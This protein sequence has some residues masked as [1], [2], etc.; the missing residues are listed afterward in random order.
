[1]A[2]YERFGYEQNP[3]ELDPFKSEYALINHIHVVEDLLYLIKSGSIV[4]LEGQA[5]S[6]KT[7][8][9][10]HIT[11][12]LGGKKKVAY[13]DGHRLKKDLDIEQ[14]LN[15][16]DRSFVTRIFSDKP[17]DMIILLDNVE[18]LSASNCEKIK[19]YFDQNYIKSVVFTTTNVD[20][21][22]VSQSLKNRILDQVLKIPHMN[23]F[24]ALR[25]IRE[26]FSDHFFLSD[27]V[28]IRLFKLSDENIKLTLQHCS[29]VCQFVV[30][31]GRGEVLPKYI[32]LALSGKVSRKIPAHS[33]EDSDLAAGNA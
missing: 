33:E 16:Q 28:I 18:S 14:V 4:V 6:G 1:M 15:T 10:R 3:F 23:Q 25:I 7:M 17:Q 2:W 30:K 19:Y 29:E 8:F 26:R 21:L 12:V 27:D 9:L 5:G 22:K 20:L 31:E 11:K 13:V 32:A 24:E